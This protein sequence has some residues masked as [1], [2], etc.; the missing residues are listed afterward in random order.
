MMNITCLVRLNSGQ[1]NAFSWRSRFPCRRA[2][3]PARR[4][5]DT[6][7]SCFN[8]IGLSYASGVGIAIV[9]ARNDQSGEGRVLLW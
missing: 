7:A 6:V 9:T 2:N 5:A 4:R 3:T 8:G 1:S